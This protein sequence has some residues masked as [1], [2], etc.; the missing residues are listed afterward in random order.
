MFLL[1]IYDYSLLTIFLIAVSYDV[2]FGEL[3]SKIHPTVFLGKIIDIASKL[4]PTKGRK[5]LVMGAA[6]AVS[7][8]AISFT[9]TILF[10]YYCRQFHE[11][12][13]IIIG[14]FLLKSSFSLKLLGQSAKI[15]KHDLTSLDLESSKDNLNSLVSRDPSSLSREQIIAATIESVSE[16]TSDSFIAPILF[17]VVFGIPGAIAYR[18]INTLDSMIGYHGKFEYQGKAS[19][20]LDDLVN[21][22]PSRISALLIAFTSIF[23]SSQKFKSSFHIMFR[24]HNLT[25][26]PNAGWPMSAMAGALEISLEKNNLYKLGDN[27]TPIAVK[28]IDSAICSLYSVSYLATAAVVIFF[29][30][31]I[32]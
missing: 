15:I 1:P 27:H 13:Y 3:P 25:E 28:H 12:I 8:P 32:L 9:L 17:F 19:A 4:L 26:S 22:I 10:L 30:L 31:R 11:I 24:D 23:I 20:K 16:N 29:L 5:S 2:L 18:A 7:M 6:L 14:S 21:W